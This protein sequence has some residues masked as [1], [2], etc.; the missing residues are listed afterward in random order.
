MSDQEV[1]SN[2]VPN[3]SGFNDNVIS[4]SSAQE[5]SP[6]IESSS[7]HDSDVRT[8]SSK[9]I[10]GITKDAHSRGYRKGKEEALAELRNQQQQNTSMNTSQ[11]SYNRSDIERLAAESAQRQIDETLKQREMSLQAN[12]IAQTFMER[13]KDPSNFE[14]YPDYQETMSL[15]DFSKI[16]N[17]VEM[18]T[19]VN[20]TADVLYEIAKNPHKLAQLNALSREQPKLAERELLNLSKSILQNQDAINQPHANEPLNQIKNSPIGVN[21]GNNTSVEYFKSKYRG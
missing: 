12:M 11:P 17:I 8:L 20:N 10:N 19:K 18:S 1:I 7:M 6:Q 9:A 3:N 4:D 2:S 5:A 15:V 13:V 14:K 16:P 21:N